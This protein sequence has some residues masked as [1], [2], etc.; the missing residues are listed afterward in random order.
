MVNR[1]G[2]KYYIECPKCHGLELASR[3]M[4]SCKGCFTHFELYLEDGYVRKSVDVE[5]G[6]LNA[7][8][9]EI[10]YIELEPDDYF[11]KV[12]YGRNDH[13]KPLKELMEKYPDMKI[14]RIKKDLRNGKDAHGH[15]KYERFAI[16][17]LD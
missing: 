13:E 15:E 16:I 7:Y 4:F 17:P 12:L 10:S 2:D 14:C 11:A 8:S 5:S 1:D 3:R 6:S 9:D